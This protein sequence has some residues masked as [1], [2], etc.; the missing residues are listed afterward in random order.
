MEHL[1]PPKL[2]AKLFDWYSGHANVEDLRGDL[3]ENFYR[4][5]KKTNIRYAR[6]TYWKQVL[7]LITSYALWKRKRKANHSETSLFNQLTMLQNYFKIAFRNLVKQKY[8]AVINIIGLAIGMSVSLLFIAVIS[9][10]T[11]YESFHE[12][13]DQI[14]RITS[15]LTEGTNTQQYAIAPA[16]LAVKLK[17]ESAT[18]EK[19]VRINSS[20]DAVITHAHKEIPLR[21]YYT[22]PDFFALFTFPLL[23]GNLETLLDKPNQIVLTASA[24]KKLFAE[25]TIVGKVITIEGIGECVVSGVLAD[26]P[27]NTHLDF[28]VL[29]SYS[30]LP[31][32]QARS[33]QDAW[34][35]FYPEYVYFLTKPETDMSALL[36]QL[37]GIEKEMYKASDDVR[38]SFQIQAL[39]DITMGPELRAGLGVQWDSLSLVIFGTLCLLILLPACFN[40]SNIS[41]ARAL[42]RSKEIGL[43]KALGSLKQQIFVQFITETIVITLISLLL[44]CFIFILI[45]AEFQSMLVAANK[46]DLSLTPK[47]LIGF[48]I[49]AL[50]AGLVAGMVPALYFSKLNPIQ[51]LKSSGST[52]T[53]SVSSMRKGLTVLQF[54][55]SFS[56]IIGLV[57]FSKQYRYTLNFD[58]GF[59][60]ANLLDV[61]LQDVSSQNFDAHFSSLASV[62]NISYSSD[63]LGINAIET[64]V[65]AYGQQDSLQVFQMFVNEHYLEN[66]GLTLLAGENFKKEENSLERSIIVNEEFLT[67]HNIATPADALGKV[68]TVDSV[69]L[70]IIGVVKNFHFMNLREPI[71]SFFFRYNPSQFQYANLSIASADIAS[72]LVRMEEVWHKLSPD[73]PFEAIFFEKEIADAYD[74]YKILLKIVGFLGVLAISISC[75][76]LLGMVVYTTEGKTKE[77]GIRKVMGASAASIT[78]L[79]SKEYVKLMSL[80]V[81]LATPITW[82][83]FDKLLSQ[84]Q[85]YS[86]S[87]SIWDVAISIVILITLGLSS[88]AT[89]TLRTAATNP[90]ETLKYE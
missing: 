21:G 74:S 13:K 73:T 59:Q 81:I 84:L 12:N 18:V 54:V 34:T 29:C 45:R 31:S 80:A 5:A 64:Y 26:V 48:L 71:Y 30:T 35:N 10:L 56:F 27:K 46:L 53:A 8:F 19:V 62:N 44:A 6:K 38:A 41:I 28:E 86:V 15:T 83:F 37:S 57:V 63:I 76:G 42:K 9:Y 1:H 52:K 66:L 78:Y 36:T 70:Q 88:I 4:N 40:Y 68:Y 22:D 20:F 16:A 25:E 60:Q 32:A 55:L 14:Y 17:E 65:I 75:L 72:T 23:E 7:S 24:A 51:A 49:F 50:L 89:Q 90:A 77:V 47:M 58:F 79:L 61:P 43:R 69:D 85:Y 39:E 82:L 87:I 67:K 2:A 11:N 33:Q 3:E